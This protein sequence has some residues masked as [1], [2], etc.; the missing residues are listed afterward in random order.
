MDGMKL[1]AVLI[2]AIAALSPAA[3]AAAFWPAIESA[4]SDLHAAAYSLGEEKVLL[5]RKS[6]IEADW[7]SLRTASRDSDPDSVFNEW[8][9]HLI[10]CARSQS[11]VM[12]KIEPIGV[13]ENEKRKKLGVF[14]GFES[15]I[16]GFIG[17]LYRV[18]EKD[19]LSTIE[20]FRV[21]RDGEARALSFELELGRTL[22]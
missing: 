5:S 3:I 1:K 20:A 11:L 21:R 8:I 6:S 17:F 12:D 9:Q 18:A 15:D 7:K 19:P 22:R 10:A 2:V 13:R 4:Q 14:I 16:K